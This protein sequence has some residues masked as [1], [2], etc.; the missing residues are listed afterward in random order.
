MAI[1]ST[2][3]ASAVTLALMS[4]QSVSI[5]ALQDDLVVWDSSNVPSLTK[6]EYSFKAADVNDRVQVFTVENGAS[7]SLSNL[8]LK[9]NAL[10]KQKDSADGQVFGM[11]VSGGNVDFS[12]DSLGVNLT[13]DF[14]GGGNN[15]ATA[16][17]IGG[18][19][20]TISADT[21]DLYVESKDTNGKSV[22][23]IGLANSK[24][25]LTGNEVNINLVSATEREHNNQYSEALGID[26]YNNAAIETSDS[27]EVNISI[28]TT[29][30][31]T[32]TE[33]TEGDYVGN[34]WGA[35]PASGIK[36]EGGSGKF[37]GNVNIDVQ[38][39]GGSA[40]AVTVT[41]YFNNSSFG[42]TW[43]N[44]AA[45]FNNLN[46]KVSS[47]SGDATG[48]SVSYTEG[49]QEV[50]DVILKVRGNTSVTANSESGNVR[51]L[52]VSGN[53]SAEFGGDFIASVTGGSGSGDIRGI[54][55]D[56]GAKV[57]LGQKGSTVSVNLNSQ[58]EDNE[59][60]AIGIRAAKQGVLNINAD[61]VVVTG[62]SNGWIYGVNAQNSTQEDKEDLATLIINANKTVI[63]V[64]STGQASS[65]IVTM[66]QGNVEI[67][68][69]LYVK[70]DDAIVTRGFAQTLINKDKTSTVQLD[71]NIKFDFDEETSK[72]SV[73]ATVDVN[74]T[75]ADSYWKGNTLVSW[76]GNP[77]SSDLEVNEMTL[78]MED[79]AQWTPS[80]IEN[81][82]SQTYVPLNHLNFNDSVI[83]IENGSK[84]EVVVENMQGTGGTINL[85]ATTSDGKSIESGSFKADNVS[86]DIALAVNARGL[87]SDEITDPEAAMQSLNEKVSV[88]AAKTNTIAEGDINGA[89]TQ[90]VAA[91]GT[92]S[93]VQIAENTKL[94][95]MKGVNA[96]ALV[97]WRDEVAYTNQR[98][99][100][101]RDH[102]HAYGAWGQ[103]YG[104]E[105]TYEG[106]VDLKTTTVQVGADASVG[107]WV[108]GAAFSYMN[109]DADMH[110]GNADTDA[111]TVSLYTSRMFD[112]GLF[113]NG[114]A[115]YGRLSTDATA[116]NMDAD[117]DNDAFS[118]GGNVGYR[119]NFTNQAFVEP[120]FG[121]Q[122][123]YVKGDTYTAGNGVKVEQDDFDALIAS[124]GARAGFNFPNDSGRLFARASVNH[125]FMGEIDGTASKGTLAD[126][127]YV[128]LGGTWF[129]Y[130]V[131]AQF[132]VT[133]NLSFWGNIDRTTGGEVST[134]YMMNA[135]LRYVF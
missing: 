68:G 81:T 71:G 35:T 85:T 114:L 70:A 125:D 40:S 122:Y 12:G 47:K 84:Q 31:K 18:G 135:G 36:F 49:S 129:T 77:S 24:L 91:D 39:D 9:V 26:L 19:E 21:T 32:S 83:N 7:G 128:D 80:Y 67:N 107:D 87:T 75:G 60:I 79:G 120:S 13:T 52:Q 101:L 98:M 112:S 134:N 131:G 44:S 90:T 37:K 38:S 1:R 51:A 117:Y 72:T 34:F 103:V 27:T 132:D 66:S 123:A 89:Y 104:G 105:S 96:A 14:S 102:E 78:N 61:N 97:A 100:F 64:S 119:I 94:A 58:A 22:Y 6:D 121:L 116:G 59:S 8:N 17:Y 65:G 92:T 46:S 56:G 109:G 42:Q 106:K 33:I 124:L 99:E 29:S 127:M 62:T 16:I 10:G 30:T 54:N 41:N 108:V 28:K 95:S 110:N 53:T 74:L 3:L 76:N 111:Y 133:K 5:A 11:Y 48:I 86:G 115:R 63:D 130:G 82:D 69:D 55:V 2:V 73:D 4:F 20:T 50:N 88:K 45:E 93:K 113:V 118:I 126:S 25:N 23:G 15:Q 43:G 57:N